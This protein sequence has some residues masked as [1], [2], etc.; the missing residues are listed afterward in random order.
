MK[1][2]SESKK[3]VVNWN[4]G[5]IFQWSITK[6]TTK[7]IEEIEYKNFV[8]KIAVI[9][10]GL[11]MIWYCIKHNKSLEAARLDVI[12]IVSLWYST[13]IS[14]AL[15]T[16]CLSQISERLQMSESESR[17]IE[18]SRDF[19][20]IIETPCLALP[21]ELLGVCLKYL[22]E[23][24]SSYDEVPLCLRSKVSFTHYKTNN[25]FR[26]DF[27]SRETKI[28]IISDYFTGLMPCYI[29]KEIIMAIFMPPKF[30]QIDQYLWS[31]AEKPSIL[32]I[33]SGHGMQLYLI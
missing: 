20:I 2:E 17:C 14:A 5:S 16:R 19:E 8:C 7:F 9:C 1:N 32:K 24:W 26:R 3:I 15:L 30:D 18:T 23:I 33:I 29:S 28:N 6:N 31:T 22:G 10:L 25:G 21:G 11:N 27:L 13:G 12:I 4:L